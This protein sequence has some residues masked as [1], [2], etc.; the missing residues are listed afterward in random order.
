MRGLQIRTILKKCIQ[1]IWNF[2][3]SRYLEITPSIFILVIVFTLARFFISNQVAIAISSSLITIIVALYIMLKSDSRLEKAFK[4][5]GKE[6]KDAVLFL[7]SN[8]EGISDKLNFTNASLNEIKILLIKADERQK[9]KEKIEKGEKIHIISI[10]PEI[11]LKKIERPY[12]L[13]W[14]HFYLQIY[15]KKGT[16]NKAIII[17]MN[18]K[19]EPME[20]KLYIKDILQEMDI[21]DI[22]QYP[23]KEIKLTVL[24]EDKEGNNYTGDAT[25]PKENENEVVLKLKPKK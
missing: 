18:K 12:Y 10:T 24:C 25:L 21:G 13:F 22:T 2:L 19:S 16:A 4:N 1:L 5:S 3:Q 17:F 9:E 6:I 20:F 15:D 14:K 23:Q 11:Y 7:N 8:T